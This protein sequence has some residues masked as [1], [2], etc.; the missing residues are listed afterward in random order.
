MGE[1]VFEAFGDRKEGIDGDQVS[2]QQELWIRYLI[3]RKMAGKNIK[4]FGN[5]L[6]DSLCKS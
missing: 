4:G 5:K 6:E 2:I 1:V 3:I